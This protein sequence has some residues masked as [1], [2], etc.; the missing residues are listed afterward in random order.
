MPIPAVIPAALTAASSAGSSIL[1]GLSS[2]GN[3]LSGVSGL[4]GGKGT[5]FKDMNSQLEMQ[6]EWSQKNAAWM[7]RALPSLQAEGWKAAGIHPL[8]GMGMSPAGG[9]SFSIGGSAGSDTAAAIDGMG[10]GLTRAAAALQ[11]RDARSIEARSASLMLDNQELQNERLRTEIRLMNAPGTP[12]GTN[13]PATTLNDT[14]K[15]HV[16]NKLGLADGMAPLS[17]VAVDESGNPLRVYNDELGDN[18][19]MQLMHVLSYTAPD[20]LYG[21]IAKPTKQAVQKLFSRKSTH[22]DVSPYAK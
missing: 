13:L 2:V 18:D 22:H 5:S 21:N 8:A 11:G 14:L 4:F 12:P 19:W 6:N 15:S 1:G 3:L 17:R 16:L 20:W 10:Q 7:A 9:S